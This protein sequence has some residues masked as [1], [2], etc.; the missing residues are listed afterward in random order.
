MAVYK[1]FPSKDASLYTE[2]PS[3]NTGRDEIIEASTYIKND[4]AQASRYLIQFTSEDMDGVIADKIN[5]SNFQVFLRNYAANV[6]RLNLESQLE[7]YSI[8]GS[9]NMGTGKFA[10]TPKTEDGVS[11]TYR[12]I[13]GSTPWQTSSF[14]EYATASFGDVA[15]G[16]VWYTGSNLDL[17]L[18]QSQSFSYSDKIDLEVDVTNNILNWYSHSLNPNNGLPNNGFI[19]KQKDS[20]EFVYDQAYT[21]TFRYFSID[22]NTIYPPQLEFRWDDYTFDTGSSSGTILSTPEAFINV[23]NNER[24]YYSES[25]ARFRVAAIEKFPARIFQTG[26]HFT[27][28]HYLPESSSYY[29]IKDVETNEYVVGF[30]NN[31]TKISADDTSS[32]FDVYMNGLEPERYY[33]LLIKSDFGSVTKVFNEDIIFKVV[34]G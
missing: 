31:Y 23:Y 10:D 11:W 8:S 1:I 6:Q 2:Y 27:N 18:V 7:I 20:D 16:G 22:T 19:V 34:N 15:G 30:D 4:A 29:A 9:W 17:N 5:D 32:Y 14:G 25:I 33:T 21:K 3:A 13:S 26:S 28:N 12:T 24:T